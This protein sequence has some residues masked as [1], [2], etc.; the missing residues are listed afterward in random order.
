[1][2]RTRWLPGIALVLGLSPLHAKDLFV[3]TTGSDAVSYAAN[4]LATPWATP[5]KA[6][7][8]ARAGDTV[9][10]RGG[11]YP[12]TQMIDTDPPASTARRMRPSPLPATEMRSW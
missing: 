8:E 2:S 12:V 9:Y 4:N 1:M 3:A 11:T 5:A 6:W 10:F 7:A